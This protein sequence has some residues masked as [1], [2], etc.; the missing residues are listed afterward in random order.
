[1]DH[2]NSSS[3][4]T[5][6]IPLIRLLAT[7]ASSNNNQ[8]I[9]FNPGGPG[10]SGIQFIKAGGTRLLTMLGETHHL[11]SFDPRGVASSI[12]RASCYPT[13]AQRS[14]AYLDVPFDSEYEAGK[15]FA[16]AENTARACV[17]TIGEHGAYVNTPQ[18]AG[19]MNSILDAI[20]QEMM[21][22]WGGSCEFSNLLFD[23]VLIRSEEEV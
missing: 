3:T 16:K 1:M 12:P 14:Q 22:Y 2:F 18:T 7:N 21:L 8:T 13:S 23:L 15:M 6:S 19:D 10:G 20:G 4:K 17:D 11:L 9:I 5:F